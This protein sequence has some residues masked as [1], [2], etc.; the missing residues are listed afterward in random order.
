MHDISSSTGQFY[1]VSRADK[2]SLVRKNDLKK[3]LQSFVRRLAR[4]HPAKLPH[5]SQA[6]L[7]LFVKTKL[8]IDSKIQRLAGVKIIQHK[9]L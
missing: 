5:V 4:R 1:R 6:L 8:S 7:G 2:S 3:G 9:T